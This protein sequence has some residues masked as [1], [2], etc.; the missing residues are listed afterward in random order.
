MF[1]GDQKA[2]N[3]A[4]D[5]LYTSLRRIASARL[6]R[7]RPGHLLDTAGLVN[8]AILRLFGSKA[9]VVQSRQH[10]FALACLL[11]KRVL[12]DCGRRKDPIFESIDES[13]EILDTPQRER[14]L[15]IERIVDRFGELDPGA[16]RV[17][18]MKIGAGM[19]SEEIA[20]ELGCS[21]GTVNRGLRRARVWMFKELSPFVESPAKH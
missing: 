8:E 1:K 19:T 13:M 12:I 2:G 18:Q 17:F 16:L 3:E 5:A 6:R 20:A 10:F 4:M 21:V 9:V 14:V 7:E 11:M 15:A